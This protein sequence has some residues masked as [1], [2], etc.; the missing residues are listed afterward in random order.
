[1]VDCKDNVI[2]WLSDE[3]LPGPNVFP[4][5][6]SSCFRIVKGKEARD[7]W[8]AA[9]QNWINCHPKVEHVPGDPAANP[10][11]CDPKAYGG[12]GSGTPVAVHDYETPR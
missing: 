12:G 6:P 2:A 8:N 9:K 4:L 1:M 10:A 3:P 5:P 7:L 11:Q